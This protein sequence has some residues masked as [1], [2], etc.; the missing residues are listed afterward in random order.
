MPTTTTRFNDHFLNAV[1]LVINE[2][3]GG[4]ALGTTTSQLSDDAQGGDANK[5]DLT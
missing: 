4:F 1:H 2:S 3:L 5:D